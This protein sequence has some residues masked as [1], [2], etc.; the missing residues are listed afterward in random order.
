MTPEQLAALRGQHLERQPD[1]P[2]V[3][4]TIAKDRAAARKLVKA[5]N[6]GG[7]AAEAEAIEP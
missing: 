4:K 6:E 7:E 5:K 1:N 3:K 2:A